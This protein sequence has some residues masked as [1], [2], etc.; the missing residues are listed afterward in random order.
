MKKFFINFS[1]VLLILTFQATM[2]DFIKVLGIQPDLILVLTCMAGLLNGKN[3]GGLTGIFVGL[4]QDVLYGSFIGLN[5][6]AKSVT[7]YVV[8]I[9]AWSL[10]R[11]NLIIPFL[12]VFFGSVLHEIVV[13]CVLF[14]LNINPPFVS[15]LIKAIIPFA[16]YNG[17]IAVGLFKPVEKLRLYIVSL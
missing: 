7:G 1:I 14:A 3:G 2:G 9:G 8:G 5:A 11:G 16:F 6:L 13:Y 4:F 15:S 12:M 10:Y 17:L